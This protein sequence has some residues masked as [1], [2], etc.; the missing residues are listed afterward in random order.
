M[1]KVW[2]DSYPPGVAAEIDW[3]EFASVNE[4]LARTCRQYPARPAF[5]NMGTTLTYRE[6]DRYSRSFA[7]WLQRESGLHAGSRVALMLPNLLQY[8]IALFG[9]LR[10]GMIAVNVNP[11]Y[12][13]RE[14]EH[15]LKD[16]GAEAIV[17]L[18]NFAHVLESVLDRTSLRRVVTTEAGDMLRPAPRRWWVNAAVKHVKKMVPDWRIAGARNWR[19]ILRSGEKLPL[20]EAR[21]AH[22]D[23]AL[24]QYTGGTTGAAKGAILSHGNLVANMLQGREWA[25]NFITE[26]QETIITALPLYHIFS[27]TVNCLMFMERAALNVLITNPRDM[28]TF[29]KELQKTRFTIITGVN[30]LYNGLMRTPGFERIDFRPLKLALGGG[31]A[32]QPAVAER[33]RALTGK[34]VVEGYG[35]TETS[36]LVAC[37]LLDAGYSGMIGLPMPSTNVILLNEED[38]EVP[39][40]EKGEIC[41]SGPQVMQG[42]WRCPEATRNAIAPG[43]WLRTGDIGVMNERG[44]LQVTDRKKDMILVSGFNVYPNEVES[45]IGAVPGVVECAVIG[46]PDPVT[47]EAVKALVVRSSETLTSDEVLAN[48]RQHLTSYKVPKMVEFR[49]ELPKNPIGKVLRRELRAAEREKQSQPA[50]ARHPDAA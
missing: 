14:L 37:N 50:S 47:G 20:E 29:V 31:A 42:Y 33:W 44:F 22:A 49:S 1:Q 19:G 15:Q 27:L 5:R 24:L 18:E 43:G 3:N 13:A 38:R 36:P 39:V 41:V 17:I 2:L 25:R 30:T 23:T 28:K 26:S 46:V 7:A 21:P 16:S 6:I 35:L 45:V 11:L 32:I 8:P 9:V 4:V 48:C 34:N 12:T 40:G 10:A